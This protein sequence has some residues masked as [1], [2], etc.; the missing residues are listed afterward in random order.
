MSRSQEIIDQVMKEAQFGGSLKNSRNMKKADDI[1]QTKKISSSIT[2]RIKELP[3]WSQPSGKKTTGIS[4]DIKNVL[5]KAKIR[6]YLAYKD[7]DT[8]TIV[9]EGKKLDSSQAKTLKTLESFSSVYVAPS[10]IVLL[11]FES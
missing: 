7:G 9:F 5:D 11:K 10:G 8:I 6:K 3:F 4:K 1:W 2:E